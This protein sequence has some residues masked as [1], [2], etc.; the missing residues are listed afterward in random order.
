MRLLKSSTLLVLMTSVA[1]VVAQQADIRTNAVIQTQG[2]GSVLITPSSSVPKPGTGLANT[3]L[4]VLEPAGGTP[5]PP[6]AG[7]A[8]TPGGVLGE[9]PA[10][11]ACIYGLVKPVTGCNP[12]TVSALSTGGTK[13]IAIVDAYNAPNAA[14]DLAYFS[15]YFGLPAANFQVVY[16]SASGVQNTPPP[17][18]AGW[19]LEISLDIQWS[20]AMAPNAKIIL[21]EANSNSFAD[22]FGAVQ[23][24]SNLV[25][26]GGGGEQSHSWGGTEF[27]GENNYDTYFTTSGIVYFVSSGDS[28]GTEYPSASPNVVA[29]GGTSISRNPVTGNFVGE[30]TWSLAGGGPSKYE[31][32]PSYQSTISKIVGNARGIPDVSAV[33]N[34]YTPVFIYDSDAGGWVLVGGTSVAS[35]V[36][37]GITNFIGSFRSSTNAELTYDYKNQTKYNDIVQGYCGPYAAYW[38]D[39]GWDYCGGI[40]SPA[41][42]YGKHEE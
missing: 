7:V 5:T 17:Y 37:A 15:S 20:H 30:A 24:A 2:D 13:T 38:A 16:A 18:D 33:A 6:K 23:V 21:V 31:S 3:Y 40:G 39:R 22:L 26:L 42:K 35:P 12:L 41:A 11:I 29:V 8:S 25:A 36:V 9:T 27:S 4:H 1:P 28:P 14:A 19:E 10:S 32:R 34:P